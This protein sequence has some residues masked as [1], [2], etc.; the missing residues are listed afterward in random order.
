MEMQFFWVRDKIAQGMY[1][2]SWHPGMENLAGYQ[3]KH[4]L[5]S[6]HVDVRPWYLH[7]QKS[8]WYLPRAQSQ[9]TLKGCVGTLKGG[10]VCNVPLRVPQIQSASLATAREPPNTCYSQVPRVPTW[11]DIT[12][13]LAGLGRKFLPFMPVQLM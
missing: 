7:M 5:G 13:L 2:I 9:S 4:H 8:P 12:R 10:Y 6:H 11:G 3:N 1:D